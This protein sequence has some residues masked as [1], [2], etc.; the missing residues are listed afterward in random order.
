[1]HKAGRKKKRIK[2]NK[3]RNTNRG[4]SKRSSS[5]NI[6]HDKENQWTYGTDIPYR[7]LFENAND[8]IFLMDNDKTVLHSLM[9]YRQDAKYKVITNG[10]EI[11]ALA[12][13]K[14]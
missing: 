1:M 10:E 13:D 7:A 4:N 6:L 8:V 3:E 11:L 14:K 9:R 12:K 5:D 2:Q